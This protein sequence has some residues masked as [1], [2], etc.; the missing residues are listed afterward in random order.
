MSYLEPAYPLV[1]LLTV[2]GLVRVWR[3][4]PQHNRPWALTIGI[5]GIVALSMNPIAWLFSRPLELWYD[6]SIPPSDSAQAIVV[7]AGSVDPPRPHR[8]YALAARDTYERVRHAAWLFKSWK[9]LPVLVCGG[10][11]GQEP[12]AKTMQHLLE[13][14]GVPSD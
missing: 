2:L 3:R 5:L 14:D 8:P 9:P 12:Y 4:S 11:P 1:L 10:G 7:L 13:S 6:H